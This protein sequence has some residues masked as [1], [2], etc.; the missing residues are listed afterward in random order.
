MPKL[1]QEERR[2]Y[3]EMIYF[4]LNKCSS[5]RRNCDNCYPIRRKI[6]EGTYDK[7]HNALD[8]EQGIKL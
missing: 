3:D 7:L 6:C 2:K 5:T 4:W 1:S 8:R